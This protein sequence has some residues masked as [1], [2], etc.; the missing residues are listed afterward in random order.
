MNTEKA[1]VATVQLGNLETEG[2]MFPDG[3]FGIAVSQIS[4]LMPNLI[5]PNNATRTVKSLL[6]KTSSLLKTKSD[7]AKREVNYIS[8]KELEEVIVEGSIQGNP[9]AQVLNKQLVGLSLTQLWSDAFEVKFEQEQRVQYLKNRQEHMKNFH[10]RLTIWW[11]QD[12]LTEGRQY[13]NRVIEFKQRIGLPEYVSVDEYDY[14][15]LAIINS[16]ETRYCAFRECGLTH[17][18][19]MAKL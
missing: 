6:G 14:G 7:L 15:T 18:E 1:R 16:K 8:L 3:S 19:A 17:E 9:E 11:K 5:T 13:M 4:R 10:K 12:G 2:L